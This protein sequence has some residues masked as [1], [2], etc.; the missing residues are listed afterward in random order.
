MNIILLEKGDVDM[1]RMV[2]T[3]CGYVYDP[4]VGDPDN[5]VEKGTDFDDVDENWICPICAAN[6]DEFEE[7][8]V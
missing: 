1:K 4:D 7:N 8:A 5:D 3:I 2:C 6:K